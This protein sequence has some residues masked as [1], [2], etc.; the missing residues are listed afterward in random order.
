M[1]LTALELQDNPNRILL[2]KSTQISTI[3]ISPT[4]VELL[5]TDTNRLEID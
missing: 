3:Q 4:L 1:F 5:N 2:T